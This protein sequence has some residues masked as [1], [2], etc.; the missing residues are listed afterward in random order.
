[1]LKML[2]ENPEE[3][4]LVKMVD[5]D[6]PEDDPNGKAV[7]MARWS[8]YPKDRTEEELAEAEKKDDAEEPVPDMNTAFMKEFHGESAA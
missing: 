2:R 7:G 5:H 6:L 4:K 3:N 8:F 1:M